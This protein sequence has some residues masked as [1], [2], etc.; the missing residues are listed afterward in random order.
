MFQNVQYTTRQE[1][2]TK[3]R[4]LLLVP[5]HK[6]VPISYDVMNVCLGSEEEGNTH[7]KDIVNTANYEQ[8]TLESVNRS[9]SHQIDQESVSHECHCL[10]INMLQ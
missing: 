2:N 10:Y 9:G 4:Y 6:R 3:E 8:T 7:C 1:S 5:Q